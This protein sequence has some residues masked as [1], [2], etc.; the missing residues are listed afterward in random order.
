MPEKRPYPGGHG[1]ANASKRPKPTAPQKPPATDFLAAAKAKAAEAA[2]RIA[3]KIQEGKARSDAAAGAPS[4][5]SPANAKLAA[6]KARI[7]ALGTQNG[8]STAPSTNTPPVRPSPSHTASGPL[9]SGRDDGK[10]KRNE[11][12]GPRFATTLGNRRVDSETP[13]PESGSR[14]PAVQADEPVEN[15]YYDPKAVPTRNHRLTRGLLFNQRGKYLDQASKLRAQDRLEQIRAVLAKQARQTGLEENSDRGFLVEPPP[16]VEWWDEGLLDEP[17]YDCIDHPDKVKIDGDN[18]IITFYVQHPVL[19]KAPQD[20]LYIQDKPM[21]HTAKEQAKLRRM[22]RAADLKEHQAKIRLG[23]EPPPPPKVKRGNMMRVMGEQAIADP[24]AVE[25]LV[26]SQIA[27]RHDTHVKANEDRK[28][29]KEER[30]AKLAENQEKDAK[31]GLHMCVFKIN[32]LAFGKHRYQIDNNG[33]QLSLTGITIFNPSMNL[34]IVEG[35]IHS[36]EKFKKLMLN[37]IKWTENG[38]PTEIQEEKSAADPQWLKPLDVSGNLKDHSLNKCTL[39]FEGE[40]KQH[41]FRKWGSKM[42]ETDGEA[43]E[44][45]SRSKLD[46][47]WALAKNS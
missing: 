30:L 37:R 24:T 32:T 3:A 19:L 47:L 33:K 11:V 41:A 8:T 10:N 27:E 38:R 23:L 9:P 40:I 31:K 46:S 13:A 26:E 15:P 6:M 44:A 39:V 42:C 45:L 1:D 29:T 7:A 5:A 43:K 2:A 20:Q 18:S 36:V 25:M 4:S 12:K 35:G 16:D 21:Y 22:R 17:S 28:L 14:A 34:V